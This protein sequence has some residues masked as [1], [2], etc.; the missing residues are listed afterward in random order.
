[1]TVKTFLLLLDQ[2]FSIWI[3]ARFASLLAILRTPGKE[4]IYYPMFLFP[5]FFLC[6]YIETTRDNLNKINQ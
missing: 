4:M 1:M 5:T 2:Y 6:I 3:F